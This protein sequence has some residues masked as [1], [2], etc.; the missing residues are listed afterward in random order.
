MSRN[1]RAGKGDRDTTN[2]SLGSWARGLVLGKFLPYHAGHAHLIRTAREQ[3]DTL[4]V[5]VCSVAREPI[6][7]S[8]RFRWVSE[9][10]RDCRVV[11]VAEEVPQAPEEDPQFWEIWT[12]LISRHA[13]AVDVVF[14][15]EAYGDELARRLGCRHVCVDLARSLYPVSGTVIRQDPL[16]WWQYLPAVVR[17]SYVHRIAIL[18]AESTGKTTLAEQ[19]AAEFATSWA[20]E[21]GRA[22]CE[23]RDARDLSLDDF[24]AIARGQIEAEDAAAALANRVIICDTDVRTTVTWSEMILGQRSDWLAQ[25]ASERQ[26]SHVLLLAP[27]VAWVNDGT[28]VLGEQRSRHTRLLEDELARTSQSYTRIDGPFDE[29]FHQAATVVA[30]ILA[31]PVR[32]RFESRQGD[33]GRT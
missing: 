4:T 12:D 15:S 25:A 33:D 10:H 8:T 3:V 19:L 27:D 6:P 32:P 26:Y 1:A 2:T 5:L 29:R 11:H 14:T 7:G 30:R 16:R 31:S 13:G 9:S 24:D 23:G 20:P 17:P 22:Y 21:Y 28:R 18:G